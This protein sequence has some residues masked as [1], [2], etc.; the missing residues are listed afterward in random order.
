MARLTDPE[1]LR[2]YK[3]ALSNYN[4]RGYVNFTQVA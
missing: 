3:N 2:C 4:F 1:K